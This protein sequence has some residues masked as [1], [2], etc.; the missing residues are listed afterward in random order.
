MNT[1]IKSEIQTT[2]SL[3]RYINKKTGDIVLC[4]N[5]LHLNGL[6]EEWLATLKD[7]ALDINEIV[8]ALEEEKV[9]H[10]T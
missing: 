4:A 7:L 5:Y 10:E 1:M 8:T 3:D 2:S 9:I 6:S